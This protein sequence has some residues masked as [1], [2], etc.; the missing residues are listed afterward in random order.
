LPKVPTPNFITRWL[1]GR[2]FYGWTIVGVTMF[3]LLASGAGQSHTFSVFLGPVSSELGLSQT[4]WAGAYG[5]ATLIAAFGLPYMGRMTDRY[6][7]RRMLMVVAVV[8]GTACFAFAGA[9]GLFSLAIAF[10]GLR[11]LGQGSLMLNS[12]NLVSRWF[13][14]R[15]GFALSLMGLGFSVSV[16]LHPPVAEWL[17]STVGWREAWIWIGVSTW[18]LLLPVVFVLVRDRPEQMG[19]RPDGVAAPAG[20]AERSSSLTGLTRAE[21][22]RTPA[23]YIICVG[24]L[25]LSSLVTSLHL[26]QV[27][28][29]ESHGVDS[30]IAARVFPISAITMVITMP[31]VGRILDRFDTKWVFAG[32][33]F[34]LVCSL[35][36]VTQVDSLTSA[37]IYAMIFGCNNSFT[38]TLFSY[39][40]PRYFGLAHLGSIQGIGQMVGVVGASVGALPLAIAYDMFG[41]YDT[42]LYI[43]AIQPAAC[44]ALA[45]FLRPPVLSTTSS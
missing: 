21:A 34:V 3:A 18:V 35:I 27:A 7:P 5:F 10:G 24:L 9:I 38:M 26:F 17:I 41:S 22:L 40:W 1:A 28:I 30:S 11:F 45:Y 39:V 2:F 36:G 29:F 42:M 16:G 43:L 31:L 8:L 15:R 4:Q 19:L 25:T 14:R 12:A 33:Q 37:I 32:G 44:I 6:G 13:E 20:G 23:F